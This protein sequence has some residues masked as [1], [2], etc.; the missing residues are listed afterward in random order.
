LAVPDDN[1]PE[2]SEPI[3]GMPSMIRFNI[4]LDKID[5]AMNDLYVI[6]DWSGGKQFS[7]K[8]QKIIDER[9]GK[10]NETVS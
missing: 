3:E 4:G 10:N 5:T 8:I 9:F 7:E 2:G 6:G 1:L